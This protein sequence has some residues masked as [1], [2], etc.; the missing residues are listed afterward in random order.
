MFQ[1]KYRWTLFGLG[2]NPE[3]HNCHRICRHRK[4]TIITSSIPRMNPF[5]EGKETW[6]HNSGA[7][8]SNRAL[9]YVISSSTVI[10]GHRRVNEPDVPSAP[11]DEEALH[12]PTMR[13]HVMVH[14]G[15][16]GLGRVWIEFLPPLEPSSRIR[17]KD[18]TGRDWIDCKRLTIKQARTIDTKTKMAQEVI[19][20]FKRPYH[21]EDKHL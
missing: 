12:E 2:H 19:S 15:D 3:V 7:V 8:S 17:E 4:S 5:W 14:G 6:S 20:V 1:S 16:N 10:N 9:P 21:K 11:V 13:R 18:V